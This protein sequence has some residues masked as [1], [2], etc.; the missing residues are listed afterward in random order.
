MAGISSTLSEL[1]EIILPKITEAN[2]G[3]VLVAGG[4]K[5]TAYFSTEKNALQVKE[6]VIKA[7]STKL[8]M[9][10]F[11][12]SS[13]IVPAENL[14][15]AKKEKNESDSLNDNKFAGLVGELNEQK[16][17]FRGYGLTFNPHLKRCEECNEYPATVITYSDKNE[18]HKKQKMVCSICSSAKEKAKITFKDIID[19]TSSNHTTIQKIYSE[20]HKILGKK[21]AKS[22]YAL[23]KI[24]IPYNFEHLFTSKHSS[25]EQQDKKRMAVWFSDINNMNSKVPIW[26]AQEDN[27]IFGIFDAV[28]SVFI[29]ITAK[30]LAQTFCNLSDNDSYLPFRIVVAGGDD[31]CIVMDEKYILDFTLNISNALHEIRKEIAN[32]TRA[33]NSSKSANYLSTEWL[34]THKLPPKENGEEKKLKPYSFGASFI[35]SDI[36]TPFKKI[37]EI[38]EELMSKAKKDTDRWD[39]SINWAIMADDNP[40]SNQILKFEKPLYIEKTDLIE[41][42][43][44]ADKAEWQEKNWNKLSF[45]KYIDLCDT[46][47]E[48]SSSHI[49][50]IVK[51]AIDLKNEPTALKRWLMIL[52]SEESDK[53]F[54]GILSEPFFLSNNGDLIVERIMTLF[55]LLSIKG[56]GKQW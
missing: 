21:D 7:V 45:R 46:Y 40:L 54:S 8:P 2:G 1:N 53:S 30:A 12:V 56:N 27:K 34:N 16:R 28:K 18:E 43:S 10:E 23:E 26:L 3:K 5:Y 31:L 17:A 6:A 38:G 13:K 4:G 9:L 41:F 42:N 44:E 22:F 49:H 15:E 11:Q 48:I 14:S 37:H 20:Y 25:D 47:S 19:F 29:D 52:D 33:E 32:K 51:K 35:I 36:H 24:K 39:N 55:E 50:Q